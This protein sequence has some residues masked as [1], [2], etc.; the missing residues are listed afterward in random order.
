MIDSSVA[1]LTIDEQQR[2][3]RAGTRY[4]AVTAEQIFAPGSNCMLASELKREDPIRYRALKESYA[5]QLGERRGT[6]IPSKAGA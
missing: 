5:I 3:E 1:P 6:L 4:A 2:S